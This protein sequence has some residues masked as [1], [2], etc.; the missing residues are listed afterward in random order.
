MRP[1]LSLTLLALGTAT[2]QARLGDTERDC[3]MRYGRPV[4]SRASALS[5]ALVPGA[6][7]RNYVYRGWKIRA[8]FLSDRV[9]AQEY[10]KNYDHPNGARILDVEL[11]AILTGEKSSY[12]WKSP[13]IDTSKGLTATLAN[14]LMSPYSARSWDR[15][16]GAK[17]TLLVQSTLLLESPEAIHAK[18]GAEKQKAEDKLKRVPKF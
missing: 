12:A 16:D 6:V 2:L 11:E 17:A 1:F 7:E 14:A 9:V 13:H 15:T 4:A 18:A 8:A 3:L 5:S 10:R